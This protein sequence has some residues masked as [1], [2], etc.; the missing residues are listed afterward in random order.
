M[1]LFVANWKMNM[2]RVEASA[3]AR[4][5]GEILGTKGT[6]VELVVAPPYTA[7]EA[8]KDSSGRWS[9][10]GQNVAAESAGAYTGET[11]AKML[12]D[13]GCR[14]VIVGHSERRRLFGED[15][16]IL[17]RKLA[18]VRETG[19]TPIYC[20]GETEEQRAEG[21][22]A[23]TLIAQVETLEEDPPEKPLVVAY[24]P[25]WAIGTGKA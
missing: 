2:T 9:V 21:L 12:A 10:A 23:E 20:L 8:A 7:L 1:H 15:G 11:S 22:T 18:R 14:Y 3:Y 4:E 6:D 24:E 19:L 13:A 25:C 16:A 5:L 17:A